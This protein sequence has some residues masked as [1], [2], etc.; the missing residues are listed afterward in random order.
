MRFA[1]FLL[2]AAGM[3]ALSTAALAETALPLAAAAVCANCHGTD[4]RVA[5]AI[6]R[7]AGQPAPLLAAK[8]KDFRDGKGETWTVMPRLA[9]GL[10]DAEIEH[11]A[12]YFA[13]ID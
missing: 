1:S 12:Q 13:K 3:A 8:L 7:I 4:G 11:L 2:A 10:N 9:K 6:P 5:G